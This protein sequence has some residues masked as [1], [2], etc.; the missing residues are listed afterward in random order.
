MRQLIPRFGKKKRPKKGSKQDAKIEACDGIQK[1][2]KG[3]AAAKEDRTVERQQG[4]VSPLNPRHDAV[5]PSSGCYDDPSISGITMD[6]ELEAEYA[7]YGSFLEVSDITMDPPLETGYHKYG[8]FASISEITNDPQLE[9]NYSRYGSVLRV[10]EEESETA[11]DMSTEN[12]RESNP[13]NRYISGTD[14]IHINLSEEE[15]SRAESHDEL[16]N[17]RES[18]VLEIP[19]TTTDGAVW[20]QSMINLKAGGVQ[21]VS[22]SIADPSECLRRLLI[23]SNPSQVHIAFTSNRQFATSRAVRKIMRSVSCPSESNVSVVSEWCG[24]G[25]YFSKG[26]MRLQK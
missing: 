8:S 10:V 6:P 12:R 1:P 23:L 15:I 20:G 26:Q 21:D 16:R 14:L 18:S 4:G 9:M 13:D 22:G 5:G 17:R 19:N 7:R 24:L 11:T 2:L 3:G 25:R